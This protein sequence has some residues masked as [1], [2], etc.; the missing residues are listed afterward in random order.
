[1][2][3]AELN[4]V[5]DSQTS[6]IAVILPREHRE[7]EKLIKDMQDHPTRHMS[8]LC[9]LSTQLMSHSEAEEAEVYRELRPVLESAQKYDLSLQQH[10]EAEQTLLELMEAADTKAE[11]WGNCLAKLGRLVTEHAQ[12]E[13]EVLIKYIQENIPLERRQQMGAKFL[14]TR[15]RKEDANVGSLDHI[16]RMIERHESQIGAAA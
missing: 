1:V 8:M 3:S 6:D 16:R 14:A 10:K 13:E 12:M 2:E 4:D 7:I 9:K 5:A 11:T 15:I